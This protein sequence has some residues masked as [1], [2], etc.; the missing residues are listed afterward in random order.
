MKTIDT[1]AT[2]ISPKINFIIW[3][4]EWI[5]KR[6][7]QKHCSER[8]QAKLSILTNLRPKLE[9]E[10]QNLDATLKPPTFSSQLRSWLFTWNLRWNSRYFMRNWTRLYWIWSTTFQTWMLSIFIETTFWPTK[11]FLLNWREM[12]F[13]LK[14]LDD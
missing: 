5:S 10:E 2:L 11:T 7:C 6:V 13:T 1:R 3:T 14:F 12:K 8:A 9:W 4:L